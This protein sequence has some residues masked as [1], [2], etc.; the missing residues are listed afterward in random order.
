[1]AFFDENISPSV[2]QETDAALVS[3]GQRGATV[4]DS[5]ITGNFAA[6]QCITDC[7]FDTLTTIRTG[8]FSFFVDESTVI[9]AGTIF[10]GCFTEISSTGGT[11][12]AY[13]A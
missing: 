3:L 1:M 11:Y 10:Y 9:P 7:T 12:I 13:R 2:T 5:Y 4:S 8:E 6:I